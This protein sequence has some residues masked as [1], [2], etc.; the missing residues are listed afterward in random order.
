MEA[1]YR[2]SLVPKV[3]L[4]LILGVGATITAIL[5]ADLKISAVIGLV[6]G[7]G[8]L[9]ALLYFANPKV[10]TGVAIV[11]LGLGIPFN[12]DVNLFYR[13]VVGV[14]SVDIGLTL[15]AALALFVL[16]AYSHYT[17][18]AEGPVFRYN[19]RLVRASLLYIGCGFLSLYNARF[20][21][22]TVLELVR[23]TMLF[24]IFFMVMNLRDRGQVSIFVFTL[25]VGVVLQ[26]AIA[27]YQYKT[28]QTLGLEAFGERGLGTAEI[29]YAGSRASGTIGHANILAYYFEIL[30]PLMF[31]MFLVAEKMRQKIWYLLA[32]VAGLVGIMT[33]LSRGG[34][35]SLPVSL[36]LVFFCLIRRRV[37]ESKYLSGL[38]VVAALLAVLAFFMYP[39]FQKRLFYEDYGSLATRPPLNRAAFSIVK[40]FPVTGVGLNNLAKVFKTY[41]RTG[42]SAL[43]IAG[44]THV[45]H[46]LYLGVWTETGTLGLIAF[47]WMFGAALTVA[48]KMWL[49][50]PPWQQGI[51]VGAAA[52]LIAQM[53]HGLVDPGFRILMN[54]SM[55]VYSMFGLIGAMSLMSR[56]EGEAGTAREP[57][58]E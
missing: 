52:G 5:M 15:L 2:T 20:V 50:A 19:R 24:F 11:F 56:E 38:F 21:D 34:W 54:T 29:W 7:L 28:G 51:A 10:L 32:L 12:L 23:L 57:D 41:D 37:M 3:A 40:Q 9:V 44:T 48:F 8:F 22:L 4:P 36:S 47:L 13:K 27:V 45:V 17:L 53:I 58:T 46:N 55:L 1:T 25:S 33:T 6:G 18:R 14:T 16:L 26:A 42:G 35:M 30:I 49:R 43:F 31:A 39:T